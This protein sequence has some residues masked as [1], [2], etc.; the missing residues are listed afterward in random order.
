M[1]DRHTEN[2]P[3]DVQIQKWVVTCLRF[4]SE[5][6]KARSPKST[7]LYMRDPQLRPRLFGFN[8]AICSTRPA[9]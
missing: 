4:F 5:L 9:K 8:Q 6:K 7:L 3:Q 2:T 1:T